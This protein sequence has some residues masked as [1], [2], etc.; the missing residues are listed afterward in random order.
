MNV[1]R[2]NHTNKSLYDPLPDSLTLWI[3]RGYIVMAH[4]YGRYT[5]TF[6][7]SV[8]IYLIIHII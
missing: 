5:S 3:L 1:T 6:A 8:I 2:G 4:M 7:M